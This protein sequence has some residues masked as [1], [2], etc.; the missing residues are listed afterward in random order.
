MND[1]ASDLQEWLAKLDH[2]CVT[3]MLLEHGQ[4]PVVQ[5]SPMNAQSAG[6]PLPLAANRLFRWEA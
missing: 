2:L 1:L 4:S 3:M 6:K 5:A